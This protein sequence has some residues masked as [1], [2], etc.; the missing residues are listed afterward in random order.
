MYFTILVMFKF[1]NQ[2]YCADVFRMNNVV[3][4]TRHNSN[5]VHVPLFRTVR[6][7]KSIFFYGPKNWNNL[8]NELKRIVNINTFKSRLKHYLLHKQSLDIH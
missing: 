4:H 6:S 2:N 5:T 7:Q 1:V 3:H 8:P